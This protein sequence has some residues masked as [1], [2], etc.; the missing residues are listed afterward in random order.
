M[1]KGHCNSISSNKH[2]Q[3]TSTSLV[4]LQFKINNPLYDKKQGGKKAGNQIESHCRIRSKDQKHNTEHEMGK[5]QCKAKLGQKFLLVV[6]SASQVSIEPC[7]L[8]TWERARK[9]VLE[10]K[11]Q[12]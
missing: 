6:N 2:S 9:M 8:Q 7:Q 3:N 10:D 11:N 4:F 12:T 5:L 1:M